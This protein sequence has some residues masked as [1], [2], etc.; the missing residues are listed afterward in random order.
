MHFSELDRDEQQPL[1]DY[2]NDKA[3]GFPHGGKRRSLLRSEAELSSSILASPSGSS[4]VARKD[5]HFACCEIRLG[6]E[7]PMS[8][9]LSSRPSD[10]MGI[11]V[12]VD[13]H[14]RQS[15]SQASLVRIEREYFEYELR[16]LM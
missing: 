7:D 16:Q 8:S 2:R 4:C 1:S 14:L 5:W 6:S 11:Q 13:R 15:L 9:Q 3:E 12:E 10:L